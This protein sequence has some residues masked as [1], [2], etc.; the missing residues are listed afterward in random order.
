MLF[1]YLL[2]LS[3]KN[4]DI[5]DYHIINRILHPF[6]MANNSWWKYVLSSEG[7]R[8]ILKD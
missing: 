4:I 5:L 8:P 1:S 2:L 6:K 7:G 3:I